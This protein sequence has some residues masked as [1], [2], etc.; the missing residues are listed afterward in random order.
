VEP[1][2][3][4]D[5][6]ALYLGDCIEVMATMPEAS[7]DA[8]VC[9][10]PYGLE[11]MGK[12]WDSFKVGRSEKYATG[13]KL[14]EA[15]A[16]SGQ[17]GAG[18]VY[19]NRPAKR[20]RKCG[21]Q[22][23]SG[24]PCV[25]VAPEWEIDNSPL[26]A[27][28]QW[29]EAWAREAYRVL[30]PGGFLLAFGGTRTYHRLAS[31]VED[32]G[33]EV[34]D[35]LA[36]M[37]GSGFP[38]SLDVSK[39]IDKAA[40][41]EREVIGLHPAPG[42]TNGRLAMGDGW[43]DAPTI[44][45][46]DAA[47]QW[48]GWGTALKPAYEPIVMARKPL[49]A[50]GVNV[51]KMVELELRSRGVEGEI[52]WTNERVGDAEQS[53]RR[54]SSSSIEAPP[55]AET[56]VEN[57]DASE[58]LNVEL[59]IQKRSAKPGADGAPPTLSEPEPNPENPNADSV[60]KSSTHTAVDAPA[61]MSDSETSSP[62]TTSTVAEPLIGDPFTARSTAR[63]AVK[64]IHP[65]TASF[66][67]IATGL[68]GSM[69]HVHIKRLHDGSFVWPDGLPLSLPGGSTVAAN[70]LRWGT[71]AI[72][73][74]GTRIGTE[75]AT[76]RSDQA[77]FSGEAVAGSVHATRGWR[78]GHAV[79]AVSAGRW[80]ANVI[81]GCA[82]EGPG[83]EAECAVALLDAQAGE[84][85]GM[86]SQVDTKATPSNYFGLDKGPGIRYG[87]GDTGG[88]SRF[89]HI[90]RWTAEDEFGVQAVRR[91]FYTAKASR[92]EREAGLDDLPFEIVGGMVDRDSGAPGANNPRAGA[93]RGLSENDSIAAWVNEVLEATRQADTGR[94]LRRVTEGFGSADAYEWNTMSYGSKSGGKSQ[95]GIKSTISTATSSTTLSET[96]NQLT[97]SRI[98]AFIQDALSR[99]ESGSSPAV[100]AASV[101][102]LIERTGTS[103]ETGIRSPH[104][105]RVISEQL[106]ELS[107]KGGAPVR[108][109]VRHNT[110]P[111]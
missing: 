54:Q 49:S 16:R 10:P 31:G 46:T 79:E 40:G 4:A 60:I 106:F 66:V 91:F 32:A 17:G 72:N 105:A 85:P 63:S 43:Q 107:K 94:L 111:T 100:Y 27:F 5:R 1:Y 48:Q 34:R 86:S 19:V 75:G 102:R 47:K 50:T 39:A 101:N 96:S 52:R 26:K 57:V 89:F 21:R 9:D 92:S 61:A 23:W 95:K 20:C 3:Q 64:D 80:P 12:A 35:T 90:A 68:T 18:P 88:A 51:L 110:H 76:R 78:T 55:A 81:L 109:S 71:G 37:Y 2:Y 8:V 97:L 99:L 93:G 83:H 14:N 11:F 58:T 42:S 84:R 104:A 59:P 33:F 67:G 30:K 13:G 87:R 65:S 82:C 7:V 103:T 108:V 22:A 29:C 38:K 28:Q 77:E 44:T 70:V 41:A 69:A 53:S 62:S 25:C 6:V 74:D 56:S 98:N 73:I 36:W 15:G 45:A 24:S